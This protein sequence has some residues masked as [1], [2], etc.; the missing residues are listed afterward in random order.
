METQQST[1]FTAFK[2]L[3]ALENRSG[4]Y[5]S[6]ETSPAN[7]PTSIL[8]PL[9][10]FR[11]RPTPENAEQSKGMNCNEDTLAAVY[12]RYL[13]QE[14]AR[15]DPYRSWDK[16]RSWLQSVFDRGDGL[17]ASEIKRFAM[18]MGYD[19]VDEVGME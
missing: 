10:K 19:V 2:S 17:D 4:R 13:R 18:A 6:F 16:E 5:Q 7:A 12:D 9:A 14:R 1:L 15:S 3:E 11:E 8:R